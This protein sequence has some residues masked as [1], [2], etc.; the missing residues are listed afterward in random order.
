[1]PNHTDAM[2]RIFATA[3]VLKRAMGELK[4]DDYRYEDDDT[5]KRYREL[6]ESLERFTGNS[7]QK[8]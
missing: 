1:M 5:K 3:E 6:H 2:N 8:G 7:Q 4:F